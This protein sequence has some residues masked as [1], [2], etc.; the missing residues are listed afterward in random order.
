VKVVT[1]ADPPGAIAILVQ[2]CRIEIDIE[3]DVGLVEGRQRRSTGSSHQ[4]DKRDDAED[5]R[6]KAHHPEALLSAALRLRV[7]S[8]RSKA[9]APVAAAPQ[10]DRR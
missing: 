9:S 2:L 3:R 8:P 7:R 4:A 6:R 1:S 10:N 5:N